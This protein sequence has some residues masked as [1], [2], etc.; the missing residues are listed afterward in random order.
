[1]NLRPSSSTSKA[2]KLSS[3]RKTG[4]IPTSTSSCPSSYDSSKKTPPAFSPP[5]FQPTATPSSSAG[6]DRLAFDLRTR[7][8]IKISGALT[9][10]EFP[11]TYCF[12][13]N[14]KI[15]AIHASQAANS[16]VFSFPEGKRLQS[17]KLGLS[18]MHSTTGAE[19]VITS[20]SNG[21]TVAVVDVHATK[22]VLASRTPAV[23][24][25]GDSFV[26]ENLDGSL[27]LGRLG[28]QPPAHLLR[29]NMPLSPLAPAR[30][31]SISPDGR[32]L[33]LSARIRGAVWN[34]AT[35][36][37]IFLV[38]GFRSSWLNPRWQAPRRI[39]PK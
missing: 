4:F 10:Y 7:T 17:L 22:Y 36:K 12:E 18:F 8:P 1:M 3:R 5:R 15:V 2:G 33:A 38:R 19:Y 28:D 13:G 14:D 25:F 24:I 16:G 32:Y 35:G 34:L 26:T 31:A 21:A 37:Q 20:G 9:S 39:H 6:A 29:A 30:S 11:V 23:D 27:A